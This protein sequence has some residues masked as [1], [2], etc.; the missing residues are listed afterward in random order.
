MCPS[1]AAPDVIEATVEGV[2]LATR[3]TRQGQSCTAWSWLFLHADVHEE[4]LEVLA[5]K[6]SGL[7]VGDPLVEET[8]MGAIINRKQHESVLAYVEEGKAQP[9]ARV[10]LDG[11]RDVSEGLTGYF[12]GPTIIGGVANDWQIAREGVFGPVLVS[13]P[14]PTRTRWSRWRTIPTTASRCSSGPATSTRPSAWRTASSPA[15]SRSTR[16][17]ARSSTSPTAAT[18]PPASAGSSPSRAQPRPSRSTLKL[19]R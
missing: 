6:V 11:S 2:R 3:C 13:S 15:R 10:V 8:D 19:G 5:R 17:A 4:F 12:Q 9:G 14:G 18:R 7:K 1:A 16:A